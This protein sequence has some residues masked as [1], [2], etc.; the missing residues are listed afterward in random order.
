MENFP[1]S[2]D[3]ENTAPFLHGCSPLSYLLLFTHAAGTGII[4]M[5]IRLGL[6]SGVRQHIYSC[7]IQGLS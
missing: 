3:A 7:I 6:L 2:N 1:R 5:Q 4:C